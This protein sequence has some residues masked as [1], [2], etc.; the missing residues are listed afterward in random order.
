MADGITRIAVEG[1]KSISKKQSID[2]APLTILAG[3]NS[4]GKSSIMR[5]LLMLKQTLDATYDPGPL[6]ISGGN[7]KFTSS[8]Q[9]LSRTA[10]LQKLVKRLSLEVATPESEFHVIF[11]KGPK[12]SLE[13]LEETRILKGTVLT[14]RPNML[15]HQIRQA[16]G[17]AYPFGDSPDLIFSIVPN[18]FFLD[19][20][21]QSSPP[22]R[23]S[24]G[25]E[26]WIQGMIHVPGLRGNPSRTSQ[27]TAAGPN[28]PAT[29]EYYV[30]SV[31]ES[32]Q[33]EKSSKTQALNCDLKHLGLAEK[34][35]AQRMTEVEIDLQVNRLAG[36]SDMV[37]IADVGLGVGQILPRLTA[38]R[39]SDVGRLG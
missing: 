32:W 25:I 36:G 31:I 29:F 15:P 23:L 19:V 10:G 17:K 12:P 4:S 13:V 5:P 1:F 26:P 28:F 20:Y 14:V 24:A 16:V 27:A 9:F 6:L 3:A 22:F 11:S 2:I 39:V 37:S 8:D 35:V 7:V 38:L 18:R 33:S 30:A 21:A 34:I